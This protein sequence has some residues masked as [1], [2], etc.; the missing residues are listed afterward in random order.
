MFFPCPSLLARLFHE[1]PRLRAE[2]ALKI[3]QDFQ[4]HMTRSWAGDVYASV[5]TDKEI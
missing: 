1:F 2:L 5:M 3:S 4:L